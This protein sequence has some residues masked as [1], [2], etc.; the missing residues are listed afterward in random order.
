MGWRDNPQEANRREDEEKRTSLQP[1]IKVTQKYWVSN[2]GY[3]V[4]GPNV[5]TQLSHR[6]RCQQFSR[7]PMQRES[8][9]IKISEERNGNGRNLTFGK[10]ALQLSAY[11]PNISRLI[12]S[13]NVRNELMDLKGSYIRKDPY[14]DI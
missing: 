4:Q 14:Q 9:R 6:P 8:K 13:A 2:S 10:S 7:L 5:I 11:S 12:L 3:F 1:H